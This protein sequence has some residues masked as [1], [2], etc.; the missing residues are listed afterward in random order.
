MCVCVYIGNLDRIFIAFGEEL[1]PVF[2]FG[3]LQSSLPKALKSLEVTNCTVTL[4]DTDI[5]V[6]S[7]VIAF[8]G[9]IK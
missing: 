5:R 4:C 6:T 2:A 9:Q 8:S 1:G 3:Q 7:K